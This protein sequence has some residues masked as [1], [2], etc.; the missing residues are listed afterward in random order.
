MSSRKTGTP[1]A[2]SAS[3]ELSVERSCQKRTNSVQ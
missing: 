2:I 3:M 1:T